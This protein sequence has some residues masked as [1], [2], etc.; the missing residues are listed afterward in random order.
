MFQP[1][2]RKLN[3]HVLFYAVTRAIIGFK[4]IASKRKPQ[5]SSADVPEQWGLSASRS[6]E[7]VPPMSVWQVQLPLTTCRAVSTFSHSSIFLLFF[8]RLLI[9]FA[10]TLFS[11]RSLFDHYLLTLASIS[12]DLTVFYV[13]VRFMVT[14]RSYLLEQW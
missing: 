11:N 4:S 7:H 13:H 14:C 3:P 10:V 1:S 2:K 8:V 12:I 6:V 5:L 9:T